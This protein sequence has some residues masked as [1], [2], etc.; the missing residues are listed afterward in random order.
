[1]EE[2][3]ENN[4]VSALFDFA[5]LQQAAK[6]LA[7]TEFEGCVMIGRIVLENYQKMFLSE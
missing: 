7:D 3:Q 4:P 6:A 2:I 5:G 1:M